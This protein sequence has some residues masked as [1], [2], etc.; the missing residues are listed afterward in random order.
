MELISELNRERVRSAWRWVRQ[1]ARD[2]PQAAKATA[3][4]LA[5]LI[6]GAW[7]L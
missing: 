3:W 6:L 1:A 5:G 2:H 7:L 4:F